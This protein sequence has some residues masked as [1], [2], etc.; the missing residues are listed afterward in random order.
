MHQAGGWKGQPPVGLK[1][2]PVAWPLGEKEEEGGPGRAR[3]QELRGSLGAGG[4]HQAEAER[5]ALGGEEEGEGGQRG[6][7]HPYGPTKLW[8]REEQ[9]PCE[10]PS[11]LQTSG[12]GGLEGDGSGSYTSAIL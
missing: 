10:S 7:H 6:H 11:Q 8:R 5:G 3:V 12:R 4:R 2:Q 9:G 1:P